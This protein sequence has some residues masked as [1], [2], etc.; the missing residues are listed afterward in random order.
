MPLGGASNVAGLRHKTPGGAGGPPADRRCYPCREMRWGFVLMAL[1]CAAGGEDLAKVDAA[2]D[3]QSTR[4]DAQGGCIFACDP[5]AASCVD[6]CSSHFF[7][8]VGCDAGVCLFSERT[9]DCPLGCNPMT[10][11][12][13][14]TRSVACAKI[15]CGQR[16]AC[17]GVCS[18]STGCCT[19]STYDK[20]TGLAPSGSRAC[21]DGTDVMIST[22]DCGTGMN[23]GVN[24]EGNCAV[25]WEGAMNGGTPCATARCRKLT[26]M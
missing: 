15:E 14:T 16:N 5:P 8:T 6:G 12:C 1:G 26:C 10:G 20:S 17:G 11:R 21:C 7:E 22:T 2:V 18:N 4:G 9:L 23:H 25:S 19:A 3:T 13:D 24:K